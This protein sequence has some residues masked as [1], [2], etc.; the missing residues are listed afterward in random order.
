MQHTNLVHVVRF[1]VH[2]NQ[3]FEHLREFCVNISCGSWNIFWNFINIVTRQLSLRM[4]IK[5]GH[6]SKNYEVTYVYKNYAYYKHYK[7]TWV[8]ITSTIF[9]I[10][11]SSYAREMVKKILLNIYSQWIPCNFYI[12]LQTRI[13]TLFP[14]ATQ[15]KHNARIFNY[16]RIRFDTQVYDPR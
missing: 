16:R 1:L 15:F 7:S 13:V 5:F 10:R 8:L 11:R 6:K 9:D 3:L 2:F 4:V 14:C 12:N